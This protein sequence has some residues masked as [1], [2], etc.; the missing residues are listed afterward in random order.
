MSGVQPGL[1]SILI[2]VYNEEDYIGEILARV[3]AATLP[4]GYSREIVVVDDASTDKSVAIAEEIRARYPEMIRVIRA[5]ANRGKGAVIRTAMEH[6]RGEF[7]LIQ[8]ADLEYDPRDYMRLLEPLV[9][10]AADVV[11]GSRFATSERRRVV[12]FWHSVANR[13]LTLLSNMFSGLNLTDMETG[14][15]A[16]RTELVNTLPLRSERFGIEPEL[17]MKLAKR[18]ARFYEVPIS[19]EGRTYEDGKKVGIKDAFSAVAVIVRNWLVDDLYKDPGEEILDAFSV[20][21]KFNRWMADTIRPYVG[22]KVLEIGAGM[23]NLTRQFCKGRTRYWA[24]DIN[25]E[26]LNRLR[27]RLQHQ[28]KLSLAI[29]DLGCKSDFDQFAGQPDTLICLNVLEHMEHDSVCT[30]NM[31]YALEPGGRAIVLVPHGQEIFGQLDVV[32]GHY[33]RYSH[34][35]LKQVMEQAG[36]EV[37]RVLSCNRISRPSWYV[38]AVLLKQ[39]RIARYQIKM[40]DRLVWLWRKIDRYLPW[41]PTSVIAIARKPIPV[42]IER[43]AEVPKLDT[44]SVRV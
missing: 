17:T 30:S 34:Q 36:F 26:H 7:C 13:L 33:R 20:A 4:V 31:F 15:K 21:P 25:T 16:F 18:Q 40:F 37:E 1:I 35:Q 23:G 22:H 10:G 29:C 27:N 28:P 24:T 3:L 8:D 12:Y 9:D 42:G 5:E 32:L 39:S 19:Y 2:P 6:A 43:L 11:Y 44:G 14:Y 41:P 38:K